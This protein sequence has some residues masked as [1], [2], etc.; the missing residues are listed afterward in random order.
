VVPIRGGTDGSRLTELGLPPQHLDGWRKRSQ[1]TG[2]GLL[3]GMEKALE[4]ALNLVQVWAEK[5]RR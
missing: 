5:H 3:R 4:T 2:M 1:P